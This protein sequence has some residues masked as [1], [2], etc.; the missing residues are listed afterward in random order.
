M[1]GGRNWPVRT[2]V[3]GEC[4]GSLDVVETNKLLSRCKSADSSDDGWMKKAGQ[5]EFD[6]DRWR[7]RDKYVKVQ[8]LM[9]S[10]SSL[11]LTVFL[12]QVHR[13]VLGCD[14]N[15]VPLSHQHTTASND[16]RNA[17]TVKN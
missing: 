14:V 7:T 9:S 4:S 15:G 12:L 8:I 3:L 6:H 16:E 1:H 13:D 10:Q 11:T 5:Q 2:G 17:E